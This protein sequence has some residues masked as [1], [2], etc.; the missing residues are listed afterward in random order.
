MCL[1]TALPLAEAGAQTSPLLENVP[2]IGLVPCG[3]FSKVNQRTTASKAACQK[4][5]WEMVPTDNSLLTKSEMEPDN[6]VSSRSVKVVVTDLVSAVSV[7]CDPNP[8]MTV[9]KYTLVWSQRRG[10]HPRAPKGE[11]QRACSP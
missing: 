7:Q 8:D 6:V 9:S 10:L 2:K 11:M 3:T 1:L 5:D 4:A